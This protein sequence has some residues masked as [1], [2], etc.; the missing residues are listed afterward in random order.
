M[1]EFKLGRAE[2]ALAQIKARRYYE[3]FLADGRAIVLLGAGGFEEREIRCVW[4]EL[5][6]FRSAT[7]H[8]TI[9][10]QQQFR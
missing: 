6:P 10:L 9:D 1:F 2:D 4:E 5:G 3:P 7:T 8:D